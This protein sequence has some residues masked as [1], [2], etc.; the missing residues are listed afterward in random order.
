MILDNHNR[1]IAEKTLFFGSVNMSIVSAREIFREA[2]KFGS[3]NI[4]ISHNHPSGNPEPSKEDI[5]VSIRIKECGEIMGINLL[6]HIIIGRNNYTSLKE[7][8]II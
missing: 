3:A 1:L 4:I 6:D 5:N 8:G 2:V 7:K